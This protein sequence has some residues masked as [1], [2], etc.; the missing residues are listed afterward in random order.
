M[1]RNETKS[2]MKPKVDR[3]NFMMQLATF[4]VNKRNAFVVLFAIACIYC[5]TTLNQWYTE[6]LLSTTTDGSDSDS[7]ISQDRLL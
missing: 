7:L 4:V 3:N 5:L 1:E 2:S 6:G